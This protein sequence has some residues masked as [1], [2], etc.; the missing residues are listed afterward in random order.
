MVRRGTDIRH[1]LE[2][3]IESARMAILAYLHGKTWTDCGA[4]K[5]RA[6]QDQPDGAMAL[7]L[8]ELIQ[9][10][11]LLEMKGGC[12]RMKGSSW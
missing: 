4:V 9:K 12:V 2:L 3:E 6:R 8:F 1:A 5:L 7:A 11:E 10:D